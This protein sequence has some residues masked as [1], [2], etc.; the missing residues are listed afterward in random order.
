MLKIKEEKER[1]IEKQQEI[2]AKYQHAEEYEDALPKIKSWC[3]KISEALENF[4]LEDKK[5][6]LRLLI[7]KIILDT[8]TQR[9]KIQGILP[10][11]PEPQKS[12]I[13][14]TTCL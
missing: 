14:S 9:V 10:I 8:E 12:L 6:L 1:L 4:T 3:T 5:K 7:N 11:Y 2:K 13:E